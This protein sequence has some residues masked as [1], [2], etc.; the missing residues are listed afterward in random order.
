MD[1]IVVENYQILVNW[2]L[3]TP[4]LDHQNFSFILFRLM[5]I[6]SYFTFWV[7][8][9]FDRKPVLLRSNCFSPLYD[10]LRLEVLPKNKIKT[11]LF[12]FFSPKNVPTVPSSPSGSVRELIPRDVYTSPRVQTLVSYRRQTSEASEVPYDSPGSQTSEPSS[13]SCWVSKEM[14]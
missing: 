14:V 11:N 7:K 5:D 10:G 1:F 8:S 9:D 13:S 3:E 6:N 2:I 4:Y 12:S